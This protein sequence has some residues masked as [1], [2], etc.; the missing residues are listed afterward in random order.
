MRKGEY[1]IGPVVGGD[2]NPSNLIWRN[3]MGE[4]GFLSP[5]M[6]DGSLIE[7]CSSCYLKTVFRPYPSFWH[8]GLEEEFYRLHE[9]DM[10]SF[11]VPD[12]LSLFKQVGTILAMS[13]GRESLV[14]L[15]KQLS[16][17]DRKLWDFLD[18]TKYFVL[19]GGVS[20]KNCMVSFPNGH[21]ATVT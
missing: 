15:A 7:R 10:R 2:L 18:R 16:E 8:M 20:D 19:S 3:S 6:F 1:L 13:R 9:R 4:F 12:K 17:T 14:L 5:S 21:H 11:K